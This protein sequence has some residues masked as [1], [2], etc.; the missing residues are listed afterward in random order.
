MENLDIYLIQAQQPAREALRRLDAVPE[1]TNKT[2]FVT[3]GDRRLVGTV[4]DG[5]IRRGL[6]HDLEISYPIEKFMNN[7]FKSARENTLN[8]DLLKQLKRLNISMIPLL[9][10]S[11][12]ILRII[13]LHDLQTVLPV[14]AFIMAGGRGERLRPLTDTMPKP[15]LKVGD[16][17]ILEHNIDRLIYFG[18]TDFY[19]CV[20]YQAEK[21]KDYFG[22]GSKK[23]ISITYVEESEPLGTIGAL[24]LIQQTRHNHLLL[25]NADIL[26][27]IDYEDFFRFYQESQAQMCMASIPYH[28]KVPY[29][30]IEL[31]NDHIISIK[32]KPTYTYYS[33]GGIYFIDTSVKSLLPQEQFYNATDL[34][35]DMIKHGK[36]IAHYPIVGYWQDIGR[37]EDFLK[38]QEDIKHI[39]FK[40]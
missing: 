36:K 7:N 4:T 34:M 19:I 22:D 14:S 15:M 23:N 40:I 10:E 31:E 16:K 29:G 27:N 18:I 13:D 33:N 20:K 26:T 39:K 37:H 32:E 35:Y 12:H 38:A 5:D 8:I 28:V 25:M 9:N 3:D 11:G 30:V 21:I 6:L 17:P 24:S 2:L 1:L